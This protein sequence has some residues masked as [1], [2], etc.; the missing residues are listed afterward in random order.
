M[1]RKSLLSAL[2]NASLESLAIGDSEPP[3]TWGH[4]LLFTDAE[5]GF[6]RSLNPPPWD[7]A[8][9]LKNKSLVLWFSVAFPESWG[10]LQSSWTLGPLSQRPQPDPQE[11]VGPV[12]HHYQP[13][14]TLSSHPKKNSTFFR[15]AMCKDADKVLQSPLPNISFGMF[16]QCTT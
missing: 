14:Q 13:E 1:T 8:W 5:R 3:M 10:P 11:L 12:S 9:N 15:H 7:L 2:P 6:S 16:P 4:V